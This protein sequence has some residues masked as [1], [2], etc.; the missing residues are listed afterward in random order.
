MWKV[1]YSAKLFLHYILGLALNSGKDSRTK[2]VKYKLFMIPY[3][4]SDG[5]PCHC[6]YPWLICLYNHDIKTS[7]GQAILVTQVG[8]AAWS[9]FFLWHHAVEQGNSFIKNEKST[10]S[11]FTEN[12]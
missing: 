3:V 4:N 1:L 5:S 11:F 7:H 2:I 8:R 9:F 6:F 12:W 10:Y